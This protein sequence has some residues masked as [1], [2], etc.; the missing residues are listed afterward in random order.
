M[1]VRKQKPSRSP[2][3]M[4]CLFPIS[5]HWKQTSKAMKGLALDFPVPHFLT[6]ITQTTHSYSMELDKEIVWE[7]WKATLSK[8][9]VWASHMLQ[10]EA[11]RVPQRKKIACEGVL[12]DCRLHNTVRVLQMCLHLRSLRLQVLNSTN[13]RTHIF[14]RQ[15]EKPSNMAST[16]MQ[17]S[18]TLAQ[19]LE[20]SPPASIPQQPSSS[21][22]LHSDRTWLHVPAPAVEP[23]P[24][25]PSAATKCCPLQLSK[26]RKAP[27]T[28]SYQDGKLKK[29]HSFQFQ[30]WE[31]NTCTRK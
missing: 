11:I 22:D 10:P 9:L 14:C 29:Y 8:R 17:K 26:A 16:A 6:A 4:P 5:S 30:W 21:K 3:Y 18:K 13:Q 19:L 28:S 25:S 1:V 23:V 2:T 27:K 20:M 24:S 7:E 12:L 15:K 31:A